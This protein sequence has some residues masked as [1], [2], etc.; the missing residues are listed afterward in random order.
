M[1]RDRRGRREGGIERKIL[2]DLERVK[3]GR[4]DGD[5]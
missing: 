3:R 1:E 4:R 2:R 5:S